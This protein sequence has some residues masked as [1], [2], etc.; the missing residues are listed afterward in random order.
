[1]RLTD[2]A[3]ATVTLARDAG[4]ELLLRRS[5]ERLAQLGA[6]VFV[7]DG[8]SGAAFRA[9][10]D[11]LGSVTL[12]DPEGRGLVAQARASLEAAAASGARGVLY[13][14]P[15]KEQFFAGGLADF[16]ERTP[17]DP[18]VGVVVASRSA[19]SYATYPPMQRR[20]EAMVNDL[21]GEIVGTVA[22]YSYGPFLL[23]PALVADLRHVE[24][25]V[26]WGWRP[27]VFVTAAHRGLR[28]QRVEGDFP[29]PPDQREEDAGERLHR[30]R[31]LSQNVAGLVRALT[32][33]PE[34][35]A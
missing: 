35:P 2:V 8:G 27:F 12:V 14:E 31:Q 13:T 28:V 24:P 6:G 34:P 30:M 18:H 4:E 7:A 11:G 22:D 26:G 21:T 1:V 25:Q 17:D 19:A 20:V 29:C 32:L 3:V 23:N 5:L 16:V 33:H 10:L 9:F 15:D